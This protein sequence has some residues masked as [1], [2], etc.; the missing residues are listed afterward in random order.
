M[1]ASIS[2]SKLLHCKLPFNWLHISSKPVN[3]IN[4]NNTKRNTITMMMQHLSIGEQKDAKLS[5]EQLKDRLKQLR[6]L[7][8]MSKEQTLELRKKHVG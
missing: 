5:A 1:R 2:S 4:Y 7:E 8:T 3:N 6:S